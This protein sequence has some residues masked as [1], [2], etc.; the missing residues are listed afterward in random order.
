MVRGAGRGGFLFHRVSQ[1]VAETLNDL[2]ACRPSTQV[3]CIVDVTPTLRDCDSSDNLLLVRQDSANA[4]AVSRSAPKHHPGDLLRLCTGLAVFGH[5]A[6]FLSG[7]QSALLGLQDIHRR[8]QQ[9]SQFVRVNT[10]RFAN[11]LV[12]LASGYPP[13]E[14]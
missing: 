3:H 13:D 11:L 8:A 9:C 12:S 1:P 6:E 5:E 2:G 7:A 4:I 14:D 10:E